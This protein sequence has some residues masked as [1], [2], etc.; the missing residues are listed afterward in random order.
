MQPAESSTPPT[1]K[2]KINITSSRAPQSATQNPFNKLGL[3]PTNS[4]SQGQG[5]SSQT[6]SQLPL[7]R[8]RPSGSE[9]GISAESTE[10]WEDKTLS[11]IFRLTLDPN[12]KQDHMGH[13]LYYT[14]ELRKELEEQNWLLQ[15]NVTVLEQGLLEA[16][17]NTGKTSPFNYMLGCWKRVSKQYRALKSRPD[18]ARLNVIREARRICMSYCIFAVTM[19]E[20][21]GRDAPTRSPLVEHLIKDSEDDQSLCHEFLQEITS[22][23]AEDESAQNAMVVAI[24]QLSQDLARMTMN[25]NYKPYIMASCFGAAA[26]LC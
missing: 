22:R 26:A 3:R 2:S 19:A 13:R 23:F 4:E 10:S 14:A 9:N 20:M 5:A 24:E 6:Q 12:K 8:S 17:S 7:K 11:T 18:E 1:T 15:L 21:F 16:G 25:D